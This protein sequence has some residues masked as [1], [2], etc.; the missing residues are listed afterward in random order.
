[1][2]EQRLQFFNALLSMCDEPTPK[3]T[4]TK[5]EAKPV[6]MSD[7]KRQNMLSMLEAGRE[8]RKQNIAA[9]KTPPTEVKQETPKVESKVEPQVEPPKEKEV[10]KEV[11]KEVIKEVPIMDPEYEEWKK[12]KSIKVIEPEKKAVVITPAIVQPVVK[13]RVVH[14]TF[15][16]P[17]W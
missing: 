16:Q 14:Y 6:E 13:P 8:K 2:K 12:Q 9:K 1:M 4:K 5:K 11:V 15:S 17:N 7:E 10:I 3:K